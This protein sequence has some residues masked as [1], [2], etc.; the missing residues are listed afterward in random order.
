VTVS[1][2]S[3]ADVLAVLDSLEVALAEDDDENFTLL[4]SGSVTGTGTGTS[5]GFPVNVP[6][7]L[8][9]SVT[10]QAVAEAPTVDSRR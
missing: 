4:V 10:V 9:Y 1:G 6:F 3:L 8:P 2:E 5:A 7:S